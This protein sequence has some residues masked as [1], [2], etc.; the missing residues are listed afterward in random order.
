MIDTIDRHDVIIHLAADVLTI[1]AALRAAEAETDLT[2]TL[3]ER[4]ERKVIALHPGHHATGRC[5]LSRSRLA[6]VKP[7]SQHA[8]TVGAYSQSITGLN[9]SRLLREGPH[10]RVRHDVPIQF[11]R[12]LAAQAAIDV[13]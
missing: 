2:P 11:R 10:H 9:P 5:H 1:A 4:P 7:P 13:S 8:G 3:R 6:T 12:R